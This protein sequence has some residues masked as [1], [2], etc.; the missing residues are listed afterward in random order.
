MR[1]IFILE[2]QIL[3][4]IYYK[5]HIIFQNCEVFKRISEIFVSDWWNW[6]YFHTNFRTIWK[7]DPCLH[8]FL[9]WIRGHR[10]TRRPILRPISAARP[11]ERPLYYEPPPP[12]LMQVWQHFQSTLLAKFIAQC[13][14]G[15][16]TS[17]ISRHWCIYFWT[18]L[19]NK[20]L[21]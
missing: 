9:H 6:A 12:G 3:S 17:T 13:I 11:P 5:F 1:P 16:F 18:K 19:H 8:Q 4:K 15:I 10:Y 21:R 20:I 2:P 7:Y 14:L